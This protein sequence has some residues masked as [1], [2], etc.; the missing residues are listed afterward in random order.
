MG[1]VV[2]LIW[3]NKYRKPVL[4][5]IVPVWEVTGTFGAFWVVLSDFAFPDII[6]PLTGLYAAAIMIFLILIVARNTSIAFGEFIIKKGWLD[7]RKLYT[8]YALSTVLL[9]LM[10]LYILSGVIGGYG[11]D[12]QAMNVSVAAW[13]SN[14]ADILFIIGTVVILVGLAPV[15]Y[16]AKDL[17]KA[18]LLFSITGIVISVVS[19]YLFKFSALSAIVVVPV[20]LTLL[21]AVLF[22]VD[23]TASLVTNKLLF[24]AW[25][26]V[27]LFSLYFMVYPTAFG[28]ILSVD[29]IT[30]SGPMG[31]AYFIISLIGGII[32]SILVAFYAIAVSRKNRPGASGT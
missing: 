22:Q 25:L 27:D 20:I 16:G 4:E 1:S 26:S 5:Y 24:L 12:L 28:G 15:F 19:L 21:P 14:P 29:S 17:R 7:E 31:S 8:G 18:S 2:L 32:L 9:G 10:V 23:S 3:W 13:I 30:T 6:I 11:V